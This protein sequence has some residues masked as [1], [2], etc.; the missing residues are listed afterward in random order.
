MAEC[1]G[2][3][4]EVQR[5]G[6]HK[7]RAGEGPGEEKHRGKAGPEPDN[8]RTQ[9]VLVESLWVMVT[10]PLMVSTWIVGPPLPRSVLSRFLID[11]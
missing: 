3:L 4:L 6:G 9:S 1:T 7:G 10:P 5:E 11:P 8:Y 2:A